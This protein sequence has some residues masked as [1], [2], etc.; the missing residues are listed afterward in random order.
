[1]KFK[2][3]FSC[4]NAAFG[5]TPEERADEIKRILTVIG[6]RVAMDILP[7]GG[8]VVRDFNGNRIGRFEFLE[9]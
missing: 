5:E 4:D 6:A 9:D 3:E 1:M 8:S 7:P 2:L